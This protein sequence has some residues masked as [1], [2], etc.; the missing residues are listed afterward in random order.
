VST[1]VVDDRQSATRRYTV[2][3]LLARE[4]AT[5]TATSMTDIDE[6]PREY[7]P[8]ADLLR[9]EGIEFTADAPT[10]RFA[11]VA[12]PARAEA[13]TSITSA[14]V[15]LRKESGKQQE[16]TGALARTGA[17]GRAAVLLG[18]T[19][20]GLVALKPSVAS[21]PVAEGPQDSDRALSAPQGVQPGSPGDVTRS[22][23]GS[24]P[25]TT[26]ASVL[27]NDTTD[28][29]SPMRQRSSATADSSSAAGNA[30]SA[31]GTSSSAAALEPP[32]APETTT[33]PR[34]EPVG[35]QRDTSEPD[36]GTDTGGDNT[37][38]YNT[39]GYNTGGDDTGGDD[40]GDNSTGD[41]DGDGVLDPVTGTINGVLDLGGGLLGG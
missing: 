32:P 25:T 2:A 30:N 23:G 1:N 39:G 12:G 33:A 15:A 10:D 11:A 40:A 26:A 27:L 22:G 24:T 14:P 17:I 38:G 37:G 35:G 18:L 36:S 19:V 9:R 29:A 28:V 3:E 7:L 41:R 6:E 31:G 34:S 16:K 5:S 20:A 4:R 13:R 21:T 8:V